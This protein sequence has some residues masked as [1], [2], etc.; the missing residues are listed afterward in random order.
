MRERGVVRRAKDK[1]AIEGRSLSDAVEEFLQTY[2]ELNFLD[3]LC[4]SLGLES[5]FNTSS[6]ITPNRPT[7]IKAEGVVRE[8]RVSD[9]TIYLDTGAIVKRYVIE[10]ANR[11][12]KIY[13]KA[14]A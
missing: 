2:D 1:L 5:R 7:G 10:E 4:E 6:E 11:I 9:Q 3:K 8:I 13:E 14:H 12:D